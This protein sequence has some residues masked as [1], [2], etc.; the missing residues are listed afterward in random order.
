[1]Q[2]FPSVT[3]AIPALNEAANIEGVIRRFLGTSYPHL[4]E[5]LVADGGSTDGTQEIVSNISR[6]DPR[7]KLISNPD[8]IQA[9]GLNAML[10]EAQGKVFLRADAHCEY[11]LDYV[12]SCV[13]TLVS[14]PALNVGG[15]QRFVASTPFQAGVALATKS[16]LGSGGAR[17]RD[18]D[19]DGYADTVFLGCFW[20]DVLRQLSGYSTHLPTNEDA[21]LNIRLSE[22]LSDLWQIAPIQFMEPGTSQS[23][24]PRAIYV[25][26]RI[27]AWYYP[28]KTWK[29]LWA[30]YLKYG[31]GRCLTTLLHPASSSWRGRLPFAVILSG[32]LVFLADILTPLNLHTRKLG[33]TGV[34]VPFAEAFRVTWKFRA[35]FE[36]DNWRGE[37]TRV[38]TFME[39]WILC[40]VAL[41]TMPIGH[42]AGFGY[43]MLLRKVLN[44][45]IKRSAQGLPLSGVRGKQVYET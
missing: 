5:V 44:R 2:S 27:R 22:Q 40:G 7:V 28:R 21:E 29:A 23:V 30:Q 38:P 35:D 37:S 24:P 31:S 39:R 11:A 10:R 19:Y 9:A 42:F 41:L 3:V 13:G 18:P 26:S 16:P 25:S 6:S 45:G 12:E 1:M 33:L 8:K 36:R 4:L 34:L 17:Y 14:V 32:L 15:A 20:T 43:E